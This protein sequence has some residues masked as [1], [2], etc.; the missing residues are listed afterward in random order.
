MVLSITRPQRLYTYSILLSI[1]NSPAM[2]QFKMKRNHAFSSPFELLQTPMNELLTEMGS[3]TT[4]LSKSGKFFALFM[5]SLIS[6]IILYIYVGVA[7]PNAKSPLWDMD[8]F[9]NIARLG[10]SEAPL[11]TCRQLPFIPLI[12]YGLLQL[13]ITTYDSQLWISNVAASLGVVMFYIVLEH[14]KIQHA[15]EIGLI[16]TVEPFIPMLNSPGDAQYL[17][18]L[19]FWAAYYAFSLKKIKITI[20]LLI[21]LSLTHIIGIVI[22][23]AF[24]V[25]VL[26][27]KWDYLMFLTCPLM[28]LVEFTYFLWVR[29]DFFLFLH[30]HQEFLFGYNLQYTIFPLAGLTVFN[31]DSVITGGPVL[32][33][34]LLVGGIIVMWENRKEDY[35]VSFF[36]LF[37]LLIDLRDGLVP[38]YFISFIG[39]YLCMGIK[40]LTKVPFWKDKWFKIIIP[41]LYILGIYLAA[42]ILRGYA[43]GQ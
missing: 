37:L 15:F 33:I 8:A 32:L 41:I 26:K 29:G 40:Y 42:G 25:Y 28:L 16:L 20:L 4:K 30:A 39:L 34:S 22:S 2:L 1:I 5:L 19:L 43:L 23:S 27:R 12:M 10:Y 11:K 7:V 35:V 14:K 24:L 31:F 18:F 17:T 13:G 3:S 21:L 38:R 6:R 9:D 36:L